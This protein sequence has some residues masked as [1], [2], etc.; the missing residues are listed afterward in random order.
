[1][2]PIHIA[3]LAL[4]LLCLGTFACKRG[5]IKKPKD[6]KLAKSNN[7]IIL[8][9]RHKGSFVEYSVYNNSK[10]I[11]LGLVI[12][13]DGEGCEGPRSH[14]LLVRVASAPLYSGRVRPFSHRMPYTC[15]K[16]SL[17]AF[18]IPTF[19][20]KVRKDHKPLVLFQRKGT[21]VKY[22]VENRSVL[23]FRGLA[24]L[25]KGTQC[26]GPR[27][28]RFWLEGT[29]EWLY[30]GYKRD[31]TMTMNATCTTIAVVAQDLVTFYQKRAAFRKAQQ[32]QQKKLH[33]DAKKLLKGM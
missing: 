29:K 26:E 25:I 1:M 23:P 9:T 21:L 10:R 8:L 27:P 33:E 24:V 20:T 30:P 4:L 28:T 12:V 17:T 6:P 14:R 13:F 5:Q 31:F 16:L 2:R 18:D 32:A 22:S 19:R 11:F 7:P 15:Q 3:L